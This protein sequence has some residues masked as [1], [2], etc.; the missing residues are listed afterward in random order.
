MT[1]LKL[2]Y[3]PCTLG[4]SSS[5]MEMQSPL[6]EEKIQEFMLEF[7]LTKEEIIEFNAEFKAYDNNRDGTITTEDLGVVNKVMN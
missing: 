7:G 1:L 2:N 5:N 3:S 6:D 4:T